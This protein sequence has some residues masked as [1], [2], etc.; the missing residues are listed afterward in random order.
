[1]AGI[2]DSYHCP[3]HPWDE[4]APEKG[5]GKMQGWLVDHP[6]LDP[7]SGQHSVC[8]LER[9]FDPGA[10]LV[11]GFW[12]PGGVS[13]GMGCGDPG[14]LECHEVGTAYCQNVGIGSGQAEV[15]AHTAAAAMPLQTQLLR[16]E[17]ADIFLHILV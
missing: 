17:H 14:V 3:E 1:M 15:L 11:P 2:A 6:K 5:T 10:G 8:A 16:A 7:D 9:S 4:F 13:A 12:G